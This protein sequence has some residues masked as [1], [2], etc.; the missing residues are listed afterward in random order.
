MSDIQIYALKGDK[1]SEWAKLIFNSLNEGI[2]RFGWSYVKGCDLRILKSRIDNSGWKSLS[3]D[4]QSC[5]QAFLLDFKV[6]DWVVYINIPEWGQCTM[7]RVA[8][9]Y[10]W[11]QTDSDFNHRFKVDCSTIKQFGRNDVAVHP[12]LR[13][14]L[15]LM[16][17]YWRIYTQ[18]EFFALISNLE[19][20]GTPQ[21]RTVQS[22]AALLSREIEPLLRQITERVQH[23]HPNYDL[24]FLLELVF[25]AMP[26][27]R[28]VVRQGGAGDHGADLLVE[29]E[30]GL[31][32]PA[33]QT[34][35]TC[36]VQIKSFTG[37]HWDTQAVEDIRRA[38]KRYPNADVGLIISTAEASTPKL[39]K[40]IEK[41]RNDSGRRVELLIGA[42]VARILLRFGGAAL[43]R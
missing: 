32:M 41:L 20:G 7:A 24:E 19:A 33:L 3:K 23:V 22:S 1:D 36:V 15:S 2:G 12:A 13:Q 16:G 18:A 38:F 4:E 43:W 21:P 31:P 30:S 39:D 37:L 8:G 42:D 40:A 35:H 11:E 5:F 10:Y 9:P 34:Q 25:Q 14:R 29:Y 17:R 27:V 6:G 26:N 28:K